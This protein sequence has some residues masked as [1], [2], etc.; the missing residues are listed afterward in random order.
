LNEIPLAHFYE[1]DDIGVFDND[2]RGEG[3][4][5]SSGKK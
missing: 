1:V 4:F 5:G 2:D 3:G